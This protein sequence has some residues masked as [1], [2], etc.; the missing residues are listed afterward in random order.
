[1]LAFYAV[2]ESLEARTDLDT[3]TMVESCQ[4]GWFYTGLIPWSDGTAR[5]L[6]Y[7]TLADNHTVRTARRAHAFLD[8]LAEDS[9]HIY[10]II[11]EHGYVMLPGYPKCTAAGSSHLEKVFGQAGGKGWVAV[12]DAACAFDPISS[13]GMISAIEGGLM[14]GRWLSARAADPEEQQD[15]ATYYAE[16]RKDYIEK[17][18]YYY[19]AVS[20]FP[21]SAFWDTMTHRLAKSDSGT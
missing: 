7:H 6:S 9:T 18:Q 13:Q 8:L 15:P 1:M 4:D 5:V 14:V 16:M 3:R 10:Q 12:G 17:A 2:F 19:G 20:R 11:S 21:G